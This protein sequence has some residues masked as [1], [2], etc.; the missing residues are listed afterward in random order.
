M[1]IS[2]HGAL[3]TNKN[4]GNNQGFEKGLLDSSCSC[5]SVPRGR[6]VPDCL[7]ERRARISLSRPRRA[8]AVFSHFSPLR[9]VVRGLVLSRASRRGRLD[10]EGLTMAVCRMLG[11]HCRFAERCEGPHLA[12]TEKNKRAWCAHWSIASHLGDESCV[13]CP[14]RAACATAWVCAEKRCREGRHGRR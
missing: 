13:H 7:P 12:P 4:K 11:T 2:G 1:S 8:G 10:L 9:V 5:V 14:D 3:D 6:A